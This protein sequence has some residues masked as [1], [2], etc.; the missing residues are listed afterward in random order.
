VQRPDVEVIMK[1]FKEAV[2]ACR[3]LGPQIVSFESPP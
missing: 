1:H 3:A 2:D